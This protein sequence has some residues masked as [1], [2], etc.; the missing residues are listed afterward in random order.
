M[1]NINGTTGNDTL[2]GTG[3]D[4][5][6][7]AGTGDDTIDGGGGNDSISGEEDNDS[8]T[9]GAGDDTIDGGGGNDVIDGGAGND[10]IFGDTLADTIDGGDGDDY[11]DGGNGNDVITGGSGDTI[12]GGDGRD[13]IILDPTQLDQNG[14]TLSNIVVDGGDGGIKDTLDL[15]LYAT[16]SNLSQTTDADGNSTSGTVD[17]TDANGDTRTVSFTEIETLILPPDGVVDGEETGELMGVGYDDAGGATDGGGDQITEGDDSIEGNGG[18]DTIN[19]GGG[20]DIVF[21]G[22]GDDSIDGGG[23]D[24]TLFG[25]AGNDSLTGGAGADEFV[26]DDGGDTITDFDPTTGVD[27][28][29]TGDN[30]YVDLSA[31]YNATT[32]ADWNA[33]NPGNTYATP[34]GWLRA[35]HRDDG[36]LGQV[37]GLRI[38]GT[39]D[40]PV[41]SSALMVENTGVVCFAAGTGIATARGHVAVEALRV[42]DLVQTM[43][44]G[45]QP[46]RWIGARRLSA[47]D[48]LARPELT[49]IRI[50]P[51][52]FGLRSDTCNLLVS[53][54]HRLLVASKI[55]Q[56]MFGETEIL[57][58]AKKLLGLKGVEIAKDKTEVAYYHLLFDRHEIVF[59]NGFPAESLYLGQQALKTMTVEGRAEIHALFPQVFAVNY[60]PASCRQI[61]KGKRADHLGFRHAKNQQP[62]L[63]ALQDLERVQGAV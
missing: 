11:V 54:Q 52:P 7:T 55:A 9:G 35:D 15:S 16:Y 51:E 31:Y 10:S 36:S 8:L 37:G 14:T 43:D 12:I 34:L 63:N 33:A 26:V 48:L 62:L 61:V 29:G 23:G 1:A 30:D 13:T 53:P 18:N 6:I 25:G 40:Q 19:A 42:D 45:F 2:N 60:T 5:T 27:G 41:S 50:A 24:D 47:A 20:D 39:D 44:N 57:M 59:A 32:L 4:D 17:V 38:L 56:R 22:D 21:G 3:D 28:G 46:I 58:P 49:P